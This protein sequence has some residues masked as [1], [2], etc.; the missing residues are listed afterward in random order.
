[1]LGECIYAAIYQS[2]EQRRRALRTWVERYNV[3][4]PHG[5]L[6]GQAP[7]TRLRQSLINVLVAHS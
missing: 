6:G 7:M 4:R 3:R 1:M 5:S 2:S